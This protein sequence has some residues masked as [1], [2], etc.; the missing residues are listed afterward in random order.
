MTWVMS[1]EKFVINKWCLGS[2]LGKNKLMFFVRMQL[3][4][5]FSMVPESEKND[6]LVI[7]IIPGWSHYYL[8]AWKRIKIFQF[9]EGHSFIILTAK[10]LGL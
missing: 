8:L 9:L 2:D 3:Q 6:W 5:P 1:W 10:C 4:N 7:E